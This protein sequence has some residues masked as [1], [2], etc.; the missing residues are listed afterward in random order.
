MQAIDRRAFSGR[1]LQSRRFAAL[2][3]ALIV[4]IILSVAGA[5]IWQYREQVLLQ[6]ESS[7][8]SLGLV[9]AEQTARYVQ[10]IDLTLQRVQHRVSDYGPTTPDDFRRM[11]G[12]AEVHGILAR[13][14]RNVPLA[15]AVVLIGAD[16]R[17]V[18]WSRERSL[19]PV[20]AAGRDF[21]RHFLEQDDP[22]LFIGAP[23]KSNVTGVWSLFF[24]RRINGPDGRF[25]G[26]AVAVVYGDFLRDLYRKAGG[27]MGEAVTLMRRDGTIL[28][29]DPDSNHYAG[30]K[31]PGNSQWYRRMA[32][33]GGE[34]RGLNFVSREPSL[35]SVNLVQT[36]PLAVDVV[37]TRDAALAGFRKQA[38][39]IVAFALAAAAGLAGLFLLLVRQ[40]N[41]QEQRNAKLKSF[42]QM[43][44]DWFWEQD[45]EH[46]FTDANAFPLWQTIYGMNRG[47]AVG[48]TRWELADPRMRPERW[49]AHKADLAARRPFRD[50]RWEW[51]R[52]DG[53]VACH[54]INGDPVF[55]SRGVF[56]GYRGTG[57]DITPEVEAAE[58]LARTHDALEHSHTQMDALLNNIDIGVC[59]FD[60]SRRL[61]AWNR[62]Y[63]EIYQLPPEVARAGTT[64]DDILRY[65]H[66]AGKHPSVTEAQFLAWRARLAG[67]D[68]PSQTITQLANGRSIVIHY[69]PMS[70]G[71]WVATHED[72]T[73][74][75][76]AEERIAFL[77]EHDALTR[78]AN[79]D[80]FRARLDQALGMAGRGT[81]FALLWLDLD[82]FKVINDTYGHPVGD[83]LLQ[84]VAKRLEGC[85]RAVD[86]VARLGGDEF[87]ILQLDVDHSNQVEPLANR[88]LDAFRSPFEVGGQQIGVRTSIGITVAPA[89]GTLPETLLKNADI[90]LYLAKTEGR[91]AVRFFE[92]EM[93]ARI[94]LRRSLEADLRMALEHDQFEVHYQPLMKLATGRV[95]GF[96]A[97]L[98]WRHPTR[99]LISPLDFIPLAEETGLIVP[100]GHWVLHEACRE[101]ASWP[102]GIAVAVNLSPVQFQRGDVHDSVQAA[103]TLSG[104]PAER[105]ELEITETVLMDQTDGPMACLSCLR[106]LG[107]AIA[108]DDFGTG[109]S[110]LSYLNRFPFDKIKIDRSFVRDMDRNREAMS[111]LDAILA[112]G[113]SLG[114]R[115]TAEGVETQAQLA[116]L[117]RKGCTQAQGYL[118]SKPVPAAEVAALIERLHGAATLLAAAD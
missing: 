12:T 110:S 13:S 56:V 65:R 1:L 6:Q 22:R 70:D 25:L 112:L 41:R 83:A 108:L 85:V 118:F 64:L 99:G 62:R 17:M 111:I 49:A 31:L 18:N 89:D 80:L 104:L 90:A 88:I 5:A 54:S 101:A 69:Q 97:L 51:L 50:F 8:R 71:G 4:A 96:E 67:P 93:D 21:S 34:Y 63:A 24:A 30:R 68:Q 46:R 9:I 78:L 105:L 61:Q 92:P 37:M 36:Y 107:V 40:F 44:A 57:R 39:F 114:M 16:G 113:H 94:Q 20:N 29:R 117:R 60:G 74:R 72:I 35:I 23:A 48:K 73:E 81:G 10:V 14:I 28:L 55:D 32:D 58:R 98:R 106:G 86:T 87:A 76:Q 115:T 95:A 45:A 11:M 79:R 100:I 66:A 3:C 102:A 75:K 82:N 109:Y 43:S 26:T 33:G 84:A 15:N 53:C 42:A 7:M 47:K 19:L 27:S 103:L 116:Q 91:G 77:A 52:P 38:E 2:S 59:F